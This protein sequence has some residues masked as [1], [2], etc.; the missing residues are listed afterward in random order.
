MAIQ[1]IDLQT[2]YSQLETV[3]K[4]VA[5]QQQGV[6]LQN[7]IQQEEQSKR[8][9]QR[10]QAVEAASANE[11]GPLAVKDRKGSS[12]QEQGS[13]G[14]KSESEEK[15]DKT[16]FEVIKDPRLGQHVDISG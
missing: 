9:Q 6:Q 10:Q 7:S 4:T 16:V 14:K 3:S 8:L 15:N 1:P 11:E 5:F 13:G 2:L 12:P